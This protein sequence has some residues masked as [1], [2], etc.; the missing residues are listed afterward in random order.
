MRNLILL[1]LL[2]VIVLTS[3]LI[4]SVSSSVIPVTADTTYPGDSLNINIQTINFLNFNQ[5][6]KNVTNKSSGN[7][8]VGILAPNHFNLAITQQPAGRAD[9]VS[10]EPEVVTEFSL[11]RQYG[12][13]GLLAHNHL[14]GSH[15]SLMKENDLI[16]LITANKEYKLYKIEKIVT[17][18]A[19]SPNSPYSNFVDLNNPST[20]LSAVDLFMEIYNHEDRLVIQTCIAK[21]NEPSWGRLFIQAYPVSG[22]GIEELIDFQDQQEHVSS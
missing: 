8:L 1:F 18:Q 21:D 22:I 5:F 17:Y 9:F 12:S 20:I 16:V 7:Q 3:L 14:A 13:I 10:N 4:P 19:L 15:F 6:V 2:I 11:S